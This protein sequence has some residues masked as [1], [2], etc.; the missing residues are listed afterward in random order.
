MAK[1]LGSIGGVLVAGTLLLMAS[2]ANAALFYTIDA[3][4]TDG[5]PIGVLQSGDE[6]QIDVTIRSDG[7]QIF[8]CGVSVYGFDPAAASLVSGI[9]SSAALVAFATG[10]GTGFGGVDSSQVVA[11][12]PAGGD[13]GIQ[14]FNGVSITGT[15]Q[16]GALDISPV[17][18]L[19]GG[20]Q[21]RVVLAIHESVT[22]NVGAGHPTDGA[23][24]VG[25]I[26]LETSDVALALTVVPEPG[27]ALLIGL[28]LIGLAR[29]GRR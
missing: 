14:V 22:L 21:V 1:K 6:I 10:P 24:G 19:A 15:T 29:A 3:T 4:R 27:T 16:T 23:I 13:A 11:L 17:T 26:S 20:P 5:S 2:S 28:G 25:G 7:E 18:G 9:T 12:D 8:G